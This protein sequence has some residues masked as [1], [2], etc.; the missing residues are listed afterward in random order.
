MDYLHVLFQIK[1]RTF[2][3]KPFYI[4]I[5]IYIYIFGIGLCVCLL[6]RIFKKKLI[7]LWVRDI[8]AFSWREPFLNMHNQLRIIEKRF[9]CLFFFLLFLLQVCFFKSQILP[10]HHSLIVCSIVS[11]SV[12]EGS[13]CLLCRLFQKKL[14]FLLYRIQ[15]WQKLHLVFHPFERKLNETRQHGKYICLFIKCLQNF[16]LSIFWFR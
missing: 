14:F 1:P 11:I 8:N 6:F 3:F 4:Y 15:T 5:Y 9:L 13:S 2:G 16:K 7:L 12:S 10:N